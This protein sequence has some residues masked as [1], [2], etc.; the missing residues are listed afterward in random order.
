MSLDNAIS[1]D[2]GK[3]N[4]IQN[5]LTNIYNGTKNV[6]TIYS[7]IDVLCLDKFIIIK[8]FDKWI[9]GIGEISI[10]SIEYPNKSKY[11][12]LYGKMNNEEINK[13]IYCSNQLNVNVTFEE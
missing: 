1:A 12:H 13:I 11:L 7:K 3:F 6:L 5:K 2:I 8:P 4:L 10:I 9:L